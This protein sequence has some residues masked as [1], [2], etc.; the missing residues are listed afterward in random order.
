MI[1]GRELNIDPA[2]MEAVMK[3]QVPTNVIEVRGF[4]GETQY[5]HKFI[6]SFSMVV[7]PLHAIVSSRNSFY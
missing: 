6:A 5:L 7:T 2:N 4:F 1:G 3:S